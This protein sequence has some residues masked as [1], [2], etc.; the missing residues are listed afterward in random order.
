MD[1][2][3]IPGMCSSGGGI[4][5]AARTSLP[6]RGALLPAGGYDFIAAGTNTGAEARRVEPA[7][8]AE[9]EN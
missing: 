5:A 2:H 9:V 7:G 1:M 4:A 6:E 3:N 8:A